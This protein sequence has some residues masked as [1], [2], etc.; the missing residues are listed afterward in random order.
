MTMRHIVTIYIVTSLIFTL[1]GCGTAKKSERS[2]LSAGE[3]KSDTAAQRD[4]AIARKF[5]WTPL[6]LDASGGIWSYAP[7]GV[8]TPPMWEGTLPTMVSVP[9][10]RIHNNSNAYMKVEIHCRLEWSSTKSFDGRMTL[11]PATDIKEKTVAHSMMLLFC[12]D[13]RQVKKPI[14]A[15]S[16]STYEKLFINSADVFKYSDRPNIFKLSLSGFGSGLPSDV[17]SILGQHRTV[18]CLDRRQT[19]DNGRDIR[20]ITN[21]SPLIT[22]LNFFCDFYVKRASV[23]IYQSVLESDQRTPSSEASG[24]QVSKSNPSSRLS[25]IPQNLSPSSDPVN[26]ERADRRIKAESECAKIGIAKTSPKW[27]LCVRA[28]L[29][30]GK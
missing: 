1:A 29:S 10:L 18:D 16:P 8:W 11:T 23:P 2:Q 15:A 6:L 25:V 5:L 27:K 9:T 14:L 4:E 13:Q 22:A 24:G 26:R 7:E 21:G 30:A 20:T 28:R 3:A 19:S 12:G 17:S